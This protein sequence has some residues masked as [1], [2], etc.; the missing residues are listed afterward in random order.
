MLPRDVGVGAV[1]A[2][3]LLFRH[4]LALIGFP[5]LSTIPTDRGVAGA[6]VRPGGFSPRPQRRRGVGVSTDARNAATTGVGIPWVNPWGG[7]VQ[8]WRHRP[9]WAGWFI[10][11]M[12]A[13][14]TIF[15][16]ATIATTPPRVDGDLHLAGLGDIDLS[17]SSAAGSSMASGSTATASAT[18]TSPSAPCIGRRW[19]WSRRPWP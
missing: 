14:F 8:L 12:F 3:C 16:A 15:L 11:G 5:A 9:R 13:I 18:T 19:P 4:E 10:L 7:V 1:A 2:S 17:A 6:V